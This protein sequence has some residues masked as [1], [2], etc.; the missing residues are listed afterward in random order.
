MYTLPI[1]KIDRKSVG[2]AGVIRR[3]IMG[4]GGIQREET[5]ESMPQDIGIACA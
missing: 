1:K 3:C 5:V 4:G 2:M